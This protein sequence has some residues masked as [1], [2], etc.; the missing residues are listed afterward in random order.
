MLLAGDSRERESAHVPEKLALIGKSLIF[1]VNRVNICSGVMRN[2]LSEQDA[3]ILA[4]LLGSNGEISSQRL[5][6]EAGISLRATRLRRKILTKEYLTV[7]HALDLQRY[8]WRQLQLLITTS[9]G[10]TVAIGREML[11]LKQVV[12]VGGT[13]GEVKIDLR[14][15]VFVRSS[16]ELHALIEEVKAISGVEGVIW[17]EVAE[18]IG[19]KSPPPQLRTHEA[20]MPPLEVRAVHRK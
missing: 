5:S 12:F 3:K 10:R 17:T 18:V 20:T 8:G 19:V 7:T 16:R 6:K 9:G 2:L 15:E 4:F 11:K 1:M 14:A 13:N